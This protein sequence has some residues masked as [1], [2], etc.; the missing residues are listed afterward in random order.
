M[1][2]EKERIEDKSSWRVNEKKDVGLLTNK[3][4]ECQT[5]VYLLSKG[6]AT[7]KYQWVEGSHGNVLTGQSDI[8]NE[9]IAL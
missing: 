1:K 3:G 7:E 9:N 6:P 2:W 8:F 5:R 4:L